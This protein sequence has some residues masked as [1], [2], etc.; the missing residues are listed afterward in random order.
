MKTIPLL[1]SA[2]IACLFSSTSALA[3]LVTFDDLPALYHVPPEWALEYEPDPDEVWVNRPLTD[4]YLHLGLSFGEGDPN[5]I[6]ATQFSASGA[7]LTTETP[8]DEVVVSGPNAIA[9]VYAHDGLRFWFVGDKKPEYVSFIASAPTGAMTA[10]IY[11]VGGTTQELNFGWIVI[12]GEFH[13]TEPPIKQ[14]IEFL[15][16]GIESVWLSDF[17]QHRS[18]TVYMDNLYF[19]PVPVPEPAS[20]PVLM[21][22]LAGL[23]S[24]RW[25]RKRADGG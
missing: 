21:L 24:M 11:E 6:Y 9:S 3:T 14:K 15:S 25:L 13:Y 1:T 22:G 5:E 19:G 4:Q 10:T 20:L 17:F 16:A 18:T 8:D 2:T 23:A 12:D 7:G